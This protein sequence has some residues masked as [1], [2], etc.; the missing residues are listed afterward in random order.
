MKHCI[1]V[2]AATITLFSLIASN[3]ARAIGSLSSA[4]DQMVTESV[5]FKETEPGHVMKLMELIPIT[6]VSEPSIWDE[7]ASGSREW[8]KKGV[9]QV[10]QNPKDRT[11]VVVGRSAAVDAFAKVVRSLDYPP[12]IVMVKAEIITV[13][14]KLAAKNGV[15]LAAPDA[16]G[17]FTSATVISTKQSADEIRKNLGDAARHLNTPIV[18]ILDHEYGEMKVT[19]EPGGYSRGFSALPIVNGDG[20]VTICLELKL[21]DGEAL[22]ARRRINPRTDVIMATSPSD[23][24]GRYM[25]TLF[26]VTVIESA[27]KSST[28]AK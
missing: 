11:L 7:T 1:C 13:D 22:K 26:S 4:A 24:A 9:T 19:R 8:L 23:E 6:A 12:K 25:L 20:T 21:W 18:Y 10:R 27:P 17:Q 15:D 5:T 16:N 2:I 3:Q 28:A 14:A